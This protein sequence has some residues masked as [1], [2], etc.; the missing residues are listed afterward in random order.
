MTYSSKAALLQNLADAGC[1]EEMAGQCID[2]WES[3][4]IPEL[5][6]LLAQHRASLLRTM[7]ISQKRIDCLD[8]LIYQT[9]KEQSKEE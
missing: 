8:F 7:H 9:K 3:H 5:L 2:L 1:D 6:R 4:R